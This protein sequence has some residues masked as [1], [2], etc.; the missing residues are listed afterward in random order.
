MHH[1]FWSCSTFSSI[2]LYFTNF[3]MLVWLGS[4]S[5][6]YS[7]SFPYI[8]TLARCW[9]LS[10][11]PRHHRLVMVDAIVIWLLRQKQRLRSNWF[12]ESTRPC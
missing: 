9:I 8:R 5:R 2:R 1:V 7:A 12:S 11:L 10:E 3:P 6:T 4:A